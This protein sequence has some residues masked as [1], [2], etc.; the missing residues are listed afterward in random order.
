MPTAAE[1]GEILRRAGHCE[2][3]SY[4]KPDTPSVS[5]KA[6]A[7]AESSPIRKQ[8]DRIGVFEAPMR[9]FS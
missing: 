9:F 1:R 8:Y 4:V 3:V 6:F 7:S 2:D 5:V